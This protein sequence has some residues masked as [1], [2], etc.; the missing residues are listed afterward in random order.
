MFVSMA[1][2][3]LRLRTV[4]GLRCSREFQDVC[5]GFDCIIQGCIQLPLAFEAFNTG[6]TRVLSGFEFRPLCLDGIRFDTE[7][8][9]NLLFQG[10]CFL[11]AGP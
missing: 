2:R 6:V 11:I 8:W 1:Q 7:A 5:E 3:S 4:S 9:K 10:L